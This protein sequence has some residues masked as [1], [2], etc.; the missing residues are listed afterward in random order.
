MTVTFKRH[1]GVHQWDLT[2]PEVW[3]AIY[4]SY[5]HTRSTSR[6]QVNLFLVVQRNFH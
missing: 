2:L 5:S 6:L 4:V 3:E 1:G